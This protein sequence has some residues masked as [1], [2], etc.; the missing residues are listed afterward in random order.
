MKTKLTLSIEESVVDKVKNLS[1]KRNQSVSSFVE[2]YLRSLTSG[3]KQAVEKGSSFTENFRKKF[4]VTASKL[5]NA[6]YKKEWHKHLEEK[7][8]N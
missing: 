1:K 5:I 2:N 8:G 3:E 6:D 7:Y 4:P